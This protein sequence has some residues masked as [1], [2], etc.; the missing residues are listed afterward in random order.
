MSLSESDL[1]LLLKQEVELTTHQRNR[2]VEI[3]EAAQEGLFGQR[4][5]AFTPPERI[6][7]RFG[8]TLPQ[9]YPEASPAFLHFATSYWTFKLVALAYDEAYV[10]TALRTVLETVE[11]QTASLFFPT[12]GPVRI[13]AAHREQTQRQILSASGAWSVAEIEEFI[14]GN[15]ILIRDRQAARKGCLGVFF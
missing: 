10:G 1:D 5:Y 12:P 11:Q 2:L 3:I 9:N 8:R 6:R 7:E 14:R 15:P 4:G 13:P